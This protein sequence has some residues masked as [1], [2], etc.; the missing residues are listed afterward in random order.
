MNGTRGWLFERGRRTFFD[1]FGPAFAD[2]SRPTEESLDV[3]HDAGTL[4]QFL[5]QAQDHV[6]RAR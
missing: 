2:C 1:T 6:D 5:T 3:E 4:Q